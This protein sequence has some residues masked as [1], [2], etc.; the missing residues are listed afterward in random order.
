MFTKPW[1]FL[2]RCGRALRV[3]VAYNG[4]VPPS[5]RQ[6]ANQ[7]Q[8]AWVEASQAAGGGGP[9]HA[10]LHRALAARGIV[11]RH[12]MT[13]DGAWTAVDRA[14]GVSVPLAVALSGLQFKHF[15]QLVA[16]G[17]APKKHDPLV[18]CVRDR[19]QAVWAQA[20][21]EDAY[22]VS[23]HPVPEDIRTLEM[24][25]RA[26]GLGLTC[27]KGIWSIRHLGSGRLVP[28]HQVL[29]RQQVALLNDLAMTYIERK[30]TAPGRL[31][32]ALSDP[33]HHGDQVAA[34]AAAKAPLQQ[35]IDMAKSTDHVDGEIPTADDLAKQFALPSKREH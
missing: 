35:V 15:E 12:P 27:R 17:L 29:D 9:A 19:M 3:F 13:D 22:A 14:S 4:Q 21:P 10:M 18:A 16:E 30:A 25:A 2:T 20:I 32:L 6:I 28:A 34:L 26:Y 5:P 1:T 31:V 23:A 7:V 11:I 33:R 24:H 8:H